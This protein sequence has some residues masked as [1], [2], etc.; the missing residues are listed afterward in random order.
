[1]TSSTPFKVSVP[2][3]THP[4]SVNNSDPM[5]EKDRSEQETYSGAKYYVVHRTILSVRSH[6]NSTALAL[7]FVLLTSLV[8][9]AS[10]HFINPSNAPFLHLL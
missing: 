5:G 4:Y 2:L 7:S 8:T 6:E 1:M 9:S 10:C 3:F